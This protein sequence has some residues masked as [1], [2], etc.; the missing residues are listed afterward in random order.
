MKCNDPFR[1]EFRQLKKCL[2]KKRERELCQLLPTWVV[3]FHF[4]VIVVSFNY[5]KFTVKHKFSWSNNGDELVKKAS[6][7]VEEKGPNS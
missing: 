3:G 1:E 7:G 2:K 5:F 4:P 6:K